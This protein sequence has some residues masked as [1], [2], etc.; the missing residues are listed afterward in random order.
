MTDDAIKEA[1]YIFEKVRN[2]DDFGNGRYVRNLME[3]AVRQQSVRLL[4]QRRNLG[5][6]QKDELFQITKEDIQMLGEGEKKE[7]ESGTARKE[8]RRNGGISF[9]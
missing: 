8:L 3:R 6:I 4:S 2:I 9:C 5:D 1:H 7:R